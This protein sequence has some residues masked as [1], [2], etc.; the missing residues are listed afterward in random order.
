MMSR[1]RN[2]HPSKQ[3]NIKDAI[4]RAKLFYYLGKSITTQASITFRVYNKSN[5]VLVKNYMTD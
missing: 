4:F 1:T 5:S 2:M 3:G